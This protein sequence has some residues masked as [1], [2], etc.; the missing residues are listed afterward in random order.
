MLFEQNTDYD[1]PGVLMGIV[2]SVLSDEWR[3]RDLNAFAEPITR[4]IV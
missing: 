3:W 4:R 1:Y 2:F